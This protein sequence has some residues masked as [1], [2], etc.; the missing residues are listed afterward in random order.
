MRSHQEESTYTTPDTLSAPS[1]TNTSKVL[2]DHSTTQIEISRQSSQAKSH[3]DDDESARVNKK[4]A[5]LLSG[6]LG[7]FD[8]E[9]SDD[10][11]E[12]E[13]DLERKSTRKSS[14]SSK[15]SK[16][17]ISPEARRWEERY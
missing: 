14:R 6:V 11:M 1:S 4:A 13:Q 2:V 10:A 16:R 7:N 3:D 15:S 9:G 8:D 5:W 12:E 17:R